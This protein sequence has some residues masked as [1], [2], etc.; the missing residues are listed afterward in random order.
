MADIAALHNAKLPLTTKY[1]YFLKA[2]RKLSVN[3]DSNGS[4]RSKA[5]LGGSETGSRGSKGG[6]PLAL[7]NAEQRVLIEYIA[8]VK[9]SCFAI[10]KTYIRNYASYLRKH[11]LKGPTTAVSA[12]WVTRFKKRHPEL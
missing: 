10:T 7:T 5:R 8:N 4:N 12:A 6:Q 9:N 11:Y 1:Y 3:K 2:G